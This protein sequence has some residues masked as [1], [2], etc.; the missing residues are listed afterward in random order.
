MCIFP[1]F[2]FFY[3]GG[4][5]GG[6]GWSW[7]GRLVFVL[8]L[9]GWLLFVLK[10]VFSSSTCRQGVTRNDQSYQFM[11]DC[12]FHNSYLDFSCVFGLCVFLYEGGYVIFSYDGGYMKTFLYEKTQEQREREDER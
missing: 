5:G 4:G 8:F 12:S 7:E 1:L 10:F 2:L 9:F 6:G 11:P 3:W